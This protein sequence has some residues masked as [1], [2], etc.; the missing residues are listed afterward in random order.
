M[1]VSRLIKE[2]VSAY[3][4][5]FSDI[6]STTDASS[7]SSSSSTTAS[8]NGVTSKDNDV[9]MTNASE[10]STTEGFLI[11]MHVRSA[12]MKNPS[13]DF[14]TNRYLGSHTASISSKKERLIPAKIEQ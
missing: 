13:L 5:Q 10:S 1:F 12:V 8:L 9:E 3:K 4:D 11:P 6:V 14:L 7:T 2:S